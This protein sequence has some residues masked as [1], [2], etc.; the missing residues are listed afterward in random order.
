MT[1][2]KYIKILFRKIETIIV[3]WACPLRGRAI[4]ESASLPSSAF[5]PDPSRW[6]GHSYPS[7]KTPNTITKDY[8]KFNFVTVLT[9]ARVHFRA[10]NILQPERLHQSIKGQGFK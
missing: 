1:N 9:L 4:R 3:L 6:S 10:I 8:S 5:A 2:L 7:R